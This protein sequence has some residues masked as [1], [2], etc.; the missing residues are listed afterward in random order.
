MAKKTERNL[1]VGLDIGTSKVAAIVGEL[2]SDGN[3]EII[4]IGSTPS[5]GLKKGVVVNLESTV[6]SIQR[7]IEEAEL[8]AGCQIRSVYAGIAGSHI[9]SLN[10]HGIVAIKDKE[11]TQYDI[12]RVIDSARAVAIPADQKILHILPQ[13]FV[14]DLQEGIKEP[15]GMSGIRLEAKVHM[16]TGSVSA[17][18][19]IVKCI[20]RCGLEVDDIVLEQLASCNSVL[21]D[22]EKELGVCLIDIG[23]GTT[24]IAIFVEGAIKH[25]AVIPI[26]GDQVTNDIAVALRT[27]TLNA[28][29]IKRKYACALTQLANVDEIIEVPSIGDRAPRKI[30]TQNLA[31]IIEPRYEE[32]MLLVQ[33][34]LRRSGYE[35]LIAAGIVLTGGSSKVMGLIDLAEEIFHMPVRMGGPQNVTGLTEVVKN[36][37]H[38][39]GVGLLMY[40]KEHQGVGRSIDSDGPS[41]FSR[42]K[43]WFQ[44]NF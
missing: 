5:R 18:Q 33:S 14:I 8:M 23:G 39:T 11:V 3:I 1:I 2:T 17:S 22:D 44:G 9:R 19:N 13:E 31:E 26:A 30:S 29:D 4:G 34:E 32:L 16:V 20:R 41:V 38:S 12:D 21:T 7:A 28:E 43:N 6:Q 10:S 25:T 40:G 42:M 36:P 35:E 15:I 27:P 24:D 37:I